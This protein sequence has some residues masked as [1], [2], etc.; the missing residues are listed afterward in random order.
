MK[1][2]KQLLCGLLAAALLVCALPAAMAEGADKT[3]PG[4]VDENN[5]HPKYVSETFDFVEGDIAY[6]LVDGGVEVA[7]WKWAWKGHNCPQ[8]T[9]HVFAGSEY[10]NRGTMS[11]PAS[12]SHGGQS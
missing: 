5:G 11:I 6:K 8:H 12:V 10:S 2:F 1:K 7:P 4:Y 9:D 3:T